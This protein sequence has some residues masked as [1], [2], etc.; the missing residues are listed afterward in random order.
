MTRAAPLSVR[1][2]TP[3]RMDALGTA[4]RGSWGATC[5]CMYPRL[6]GAAFRELRAEGRR[7]AMAALAR[8]SRAPG[9]VA[10]S[11]EDPVGWIAVAPRGELAR[12]AASRATPPVDDAPVWVVPCVTVRKDARGRG[13]ALALVEA[14]AGWA[15]AQGAP[16]VEAYPRAGSGRVGD[17][18]AYFGVEPLF[19]RAGFRVARGPLEDRP[20]NWPARLAMRID[21]ARAAPANRTRRRACPCTC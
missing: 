15:A 6:T 2:L 4:L 13:V 16:A 9:L 21:T 14:A 3:E 5:W 1:P 7:A 20:R 18:S 11:G 17:D 19:R 12:V 10:F 8:R